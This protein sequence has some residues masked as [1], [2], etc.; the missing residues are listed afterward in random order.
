M[1]K[2]LSEK[3]NIPYIELEK[4]EE[5]LRDAPDDW[6]KRSF[7]ENFER[8]EKQEYL[9]PICLLW[10]EKKIKTEDIPNLTSEIIKCDLQNEVY[11]I[12]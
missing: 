1:S 4:L 12:F 11:K 5:L 7:E 6:V 10:K 8:A 3:L 2:N 9:R